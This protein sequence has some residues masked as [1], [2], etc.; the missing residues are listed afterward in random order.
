MYQFQTDELSADYL[1]NNLRSF[2]DEQPL[3]NMICFNLPELPWEKL[4]N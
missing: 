1:L 3:K 2:D 4:S